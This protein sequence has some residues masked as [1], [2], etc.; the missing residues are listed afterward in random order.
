ME[1]KTWYSWHPWFILL[2][3]ELSTFHTFTVLLLDCRHATNI[4]LV[5]SVFN[6]Y[7]TLRN[8]EN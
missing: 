4:S 8:E 3:F 5:C 1:A 7:R 2:Y 6:K